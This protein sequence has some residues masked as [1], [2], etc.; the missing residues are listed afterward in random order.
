[1]VTAYDI[2]SGLGKAD[3]PQSLRSFCR[4][5]EDASVK[6]GAFLK[7]I[8]DQC[9]KDSQLDWNDLF[10]DVRG[11]S[12]S[13][14]LQASKAVDAACAGQDENVRIA[15]TNAEGSGI[16]PSESPS[17]VVDT[18]RFALEMT[19]AELLGDDGDALET[20]IKNSIENARMKVISRREEREFGYGSHRFKVSSRL[21]MFV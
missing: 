16:S 5:L 12:Y 20:R 9:D 6:Q 18:M 11:R 3:V 17:A 14:M 19:R 2:Y 13:Q 4:L 15:S 8:K 1:M 10:H 7:A 21:Y